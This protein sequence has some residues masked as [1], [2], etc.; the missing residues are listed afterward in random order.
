MKTIATKIS[1]ILPFLSPTTFSTPF[2]LCHFYGPNQLQ[3]RYQSTRIGS[4]GPNCCKVS[5]TFQATIP[6]PNTCVTHAVNSLNLSGLLFSRLECFF[7]PIKHGT[8]KWAPV[9]N[10]F[11]LLS[12]DLKHFSNILL[13]FCPF[14]F[15]HFINFFL[16]IFLSSYVRSFEIEKKNSFTELTLHER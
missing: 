7:F 11:S 13:H 5:M 14:F 8:S 16:N 12:L 10:L 9:R 1:Q 6:S 15:H 2:L 3:T 4:G